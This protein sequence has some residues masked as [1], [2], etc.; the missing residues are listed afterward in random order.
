[1]LI[2]LMS[3][4]AEK[5]DARWAEVTRIGIQMP[6][7]STAAIREFKITQMDLRTDITFFHLLVESYHRLTGNSLLS[8]DLKGARGRDWLYDEAPFALLAHN[9]APDPI[10]IYAN[11]TAQRLFEYDW[12]EFTALPSRL[13]AEAPERDDRQRFLEQVRQNSFVKGYSGIRVTKSGKRF[14]IE[15]ATIWQLTDSNRVYFGQ[16]ALIGSTRAD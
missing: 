5:A 4:L 2:S 9:S 16:A 8:D 12:A 6:T 13:S 1:M 3:S 11:M 7:D 14:R 10:F 15:D